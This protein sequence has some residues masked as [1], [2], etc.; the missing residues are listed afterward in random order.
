MTEALDLLHPTRIGHGIAASHDPE[1]VRRLARQAVC[2]DVCPTSNVELGAVDG[3]DVHPLADLIAAGVPC[4]LGADDP[5]VFGVG[6]LDEFERA[7]ERLGLTDD[8][9]ADLVRNSL[10]HA[11]AP[12]VLKASWLGTATDG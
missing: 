7:R 3:W 12:K 6:L 10:I 5:I 11:S 9:L 1:V 8:M 2:L 4:T